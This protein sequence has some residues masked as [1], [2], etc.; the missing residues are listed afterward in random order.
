VSQGNRIL[1]TT[2]AIRGAAPFI[3]HHRFVDKDKSRLRRCS[4]RP[5]LKRPLRPALATLRC[6]KPPRLSAS[7]LV[8][9]QQDAPRFSVFNPAPHV[10]AHGGR[11]AVRENG[12]EIDGDGNVGARNGQNPFFRSHRE[13]QG[14]RALV[15]PPV[16]F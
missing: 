12:K 8:V 1:T 13:P 11:G 14:I 9:P 5:P 15:L 2:N 7:F 4:A 16:F 6:R 3:N 10:A